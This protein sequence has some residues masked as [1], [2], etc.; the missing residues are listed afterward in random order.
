M[1]EEPSAPLPR[2]WIWV[3]VMLVLSAAALMLVLTIGRV[4]PPSRATPSQAANVERVPAKTGIGATGRYASSGMVVTPIKVYFRT[5]QRTE[6]EIKVPHAMN[7]YK[8]EHGH[9][10]KTPEDF[11]RD[12]I[13]FNQI[14]LPD[15]P[16]G[17]RY[18]Y[19]AESG[20]LQ[21]ER[22]IE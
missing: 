4:D 17:H 21:V 13:E 19:D 8:A 14:E 22:P 16:A 1:N 3:I 10:P 18:L 12:I 2:R 20:E 15:L 6:L 9:F 5:K 11:T 7:L